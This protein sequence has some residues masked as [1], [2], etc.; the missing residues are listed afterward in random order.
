MTDSVSGA[1]AVSR[2][3]VLAAA[4]M[5]FG[6]L[7][8][9][10][11]VWPTG[12]ARAG[13]ASVPSAP[14]GVL[15][16]AG[17][18]EATLSWKA[19]V[20]PGASPVTGYS[21]TVHR[22]SVTGTPQWYPASTT[23]TTIL[24]L[25]NGIGYQFTVVATSAAGKSPASAW[26]N[27]V[28]PSA[29]P[30][31]P[32]GVTAVAAQ[33]HVTVTWIA[34]NAN[35]R[36]I[37]GYE[38]IPYVG[39]AAQPVKTF[40]STATSQVIYALAST[41]AYSFRVAALNG[42]GAGPLSA[43][44]AA[45]KPTALPSAPLSVVAVAGSA[46]VTLSWAAPTK[47]GNLPITGYY[48][49]AHA[50]SSSAP[51]WFAPSVTSATIGGLTNNTG[52]QFSVV[53]A[54]ADGLS[55]ASI[56][57]NY[58]T[59]AAVPNTPT[60]GSETGGDGQATVWWKVPAGTWDPISRYLI[61]PYI[62]G[63]AQT[64]R[65]VNSTVN[66]QTVAGLVDGT[67]YQFT[68]T[69]VNVIG[70]SATSGLTNTV[71]PATDPTTFDDEF[72]A[73]AGSGPNA[74]LTTAMWYQDPCWV[75]GCGNESNTQYLSSNVYED[76]IGDLVLQAGNQPT[77]GAE[78]GTEKCAYTG[79]GIEMFN[80]SGASTWSQEYGTFTARIKMPAG[81]GLWPAFWL[82]GS[83]HGGVGWPACGEIDAL[84]ADGSSP[85]TVQQH[86]HYGTSNDNPTGSSTQLPAGESITDWHT[87]SITWTPSGMVW[88]IDGTPT[89][90][91]LASTVGASTYSS[92]FAHPFSVILDI[93]VGGRDT[94]TPNASTAFPARMLV[95]YV[96]VTRT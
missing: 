83:N 93:T 85:S 81:S 94:S 15:A 40:S 67:T 79:A 96:R 72:N 90:V 51:R 87:Y 48:V 19:P 12:V 24:G 1:M 33:G 26:S 3:K 20:S 34:P 80:T 44:S 65:V 11:S 82:A 17:G 14:S 27:Y 60:A 43:P 9:L 69:A 92:F 53:A 28:T 50:G 32:T 74:G 47:T 4:L 42:E 29:V 39:T 59:P 49:T 86:I 64:P 22:G 37:S 23:S 16:V 41:Q 36:A 2:V 10:I 46:E 71:T 58:V 77:A 91:I 75:S 56:W 78:C 8:G 18:W 68:V 45:V 38:V 25:K 66:A 31:A 62:D 7:G 6:L 55:P 89:M 95:D 84:E 35:G 61:T 30:S 52:Y 76:G 54:N 57:S 21:V 70:D 5:V 63:K 73:A 88:A 13:A